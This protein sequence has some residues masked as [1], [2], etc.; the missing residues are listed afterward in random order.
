M[1]EPG[2]NEAGLGSPERIG[3]EWRPGLRRG[4]LTARDKPPRRSGIAGNSG[5]TSRQSSRQR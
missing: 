5:W 4:D 3:L 1:L 2:L